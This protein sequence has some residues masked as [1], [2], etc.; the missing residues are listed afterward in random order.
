M[1]EL[2]KILHGKTFHRA[3]SFQFQI[4]SNN[5]GKTVV[6]SFIEGRSALLGSVISDKDTVA[7]RTQSQV[8]H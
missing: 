6:Q 2:R 1:R 7:T 5:N 3:I 4:P 8:Y